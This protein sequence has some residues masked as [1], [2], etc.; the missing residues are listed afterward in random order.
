MPKVKDDAP[1]RVECRYRLSWTNTEDSYPGGGNVKLALDFLGARD[2]SV[3]WV[4]RGPGY[5]Q[6]AEFV[7]SAPI[8]KQQV[9]DVVGSD[10]FRVFKRVVVLKIKAKQLE[11]R[12]EKR[13]WW[14]WFWPW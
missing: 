10:V 6:L 13:R 9:K 7:S 1:E 8:T 5:D 3:N 4:F 2:V 11:E 14:H 12:L